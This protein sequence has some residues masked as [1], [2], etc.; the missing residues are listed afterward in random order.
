LL[1]REAELALIEDRIGAATEARGSLLLIEGPAGIGK[2]ELVD[3][4][5]ERAAAAG[6]EALSARGGE[7]ERSLGFGIVRQLFE[8]RLAAASAAERRKLLAGAASLVAPALG[9]EPAAQ[10]PA[11]ASL[12]LGDP[13]ASLHHG[14][15]WLSANLSESSPLLLSIDDLH[16]ADPSSVRWLIYLARRLEDLRVLVVAASRDGEPGI[17]P[18]LLGAVRSEAAGEVVRPAHLSDAASAELVRGGLGNR[19]EP[20]FCAACHRA[21]G[22]NPFLL[23]ELIDAIRA[24]GIPPVAASIERIEELGPK[25][26]SISIMLRLARLPAGSEMLTRS[27]AILGSEAELRHA[28]ALAE[29]D[30]TTAAEVADALRA[31]SILAAGRPLRFAHPLLRTAVY[32]QIPEAERAIAHARAAQALRDDG[33][34]ADEVAAQLLHA[35]PAA[36]EWVVGVLRGAASDAIARGT[37]DAAVGYL[38]RALL[39]PPPGEL[40]TDLIRELLDAGVRAADVSVFEGISEDPVGELTR[41]P[42]STMTSARVL[43]PWLAATVPLNEATELAKRAIAV[44]NE[45]GDHRLAVQLELQLLSVVQITPDEALKRLERYAGRIE[46]GAAEERTWLAMCAWWRHFARGPVSEST[47]LARRALEGGRLLLEQ[48]ETP[49]VGQV[50][51]VLLRADQLDEAE[52]WIE[53][54]LD[55]ARQRGSITSFTGAGST[56]TQL[57]YQ[58]GDVAAASAEARTHLEMSREHGLT[59]VVPVYIAWLVDALIERGE[60]TEADEQLTAG[61]LVGELPDHY[62]MTP[63]RFSRARLR[64]AQGRTGDA[65]EDLRALL[66]FTDD[67]WPAIYPIASTIAL[68][69][70]D[71]NPNEARSLAQWEMERARQWDTPRAIGVSLRALG[72]IEGGEQGIEL[73]REAVATLESSPARLEHARALADLGAALRRAKHRSESREVLKHAVETANRCGAVVIERRAREELAATG[74]KP[75]RVMLTGVESLT[76]SELRVARM[77]AEGMENKDIAQA[78]F[79]TPKTVETHLGHVYRKLDISSRKELPAA[80]ASGDR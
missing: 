6:M 76:P 14:L 20:S 64:L 72:L 7:L 45:A 51:L 67:T 13:A 66:R 27:V 43:G 73:L 62:R 65:L 56:V 1:E 75:R 37:P 5:R 28:A 10:A 31:T 36:Q 50:I 38:R 30:Q 78:L 21:S 8:A 22:G 40:R 2:T 17:D 47:E 12:A 15:Y 23:N 18:I 46:P 16:W 61:G 70:R 9:S 57:A 11:A 32:D 69:S 41:E 19:T 58:R 24:D 4:T 35:E 49:L 48:P 54:V 63:V 80:L 59:I 68:A 26:I 77:A 34:P 25:A 39:E 3:A 71:Q 53:R 52:L 29:L 60:L 44:A 55:H 42:A 74:A 33:A 79:V